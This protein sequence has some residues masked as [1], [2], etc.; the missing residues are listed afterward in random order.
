MMKT[1][2][3][4]TFD[5][6]EFKRAAQ[7]RIYERIKDMTPEEE[8]AYFRQAVESGPFAEWWRSRAAAGMVPPEGGEAQQR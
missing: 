4:K 7:A 1:K 2:T 8:I 6:V 5:C 3:R